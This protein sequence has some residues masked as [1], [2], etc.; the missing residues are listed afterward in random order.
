MRPVEQRLGD[1]RIAHKP[2]DGQDEDRGHERIAG[3]SIWTCELWPRAPQAIDG[4]DGQCIEGPD[5]QHERVAQR[6]ERLTEHEC[7][8]QQRGEQNR[9]MG[10]LEPPVHA[11]QRREQQA[12]LGHREEHPRR[13][14]HDAVQR[15]EGRHRDQRRDQHRADAAED[16]HHGVGG[17]ERRL[18]DAIERQ[19]IQV[20]DV[21][22]HVNGQQR[23][24]AA[25]DGDR[26]VALRDSSPRRP[27][28][29][30][31]QSRRTPTAR[32]PEPGR[33]RLRRRW[34][35]QRRPT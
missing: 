11:G 19:D 21:G 31:P 34:Y 9:Q 24:G 16:G 20:G 7:H 27:R 22:E 23:Q 35:L 2:D 12:V 14:Q 3:H 1:E 13:R 5:R 10:R 26:Q 33:D 29:R 25:D 17:H 8:P 32:S 30:G 4:R 18:P 6:L 15:A 28:T